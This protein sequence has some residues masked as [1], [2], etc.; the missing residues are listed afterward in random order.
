MRIAIGLAAALILS[1]CASNPGPETDTGVAAG[2][3]SDPMPGEPVL[4]HTFTQ[5]SGEFVRVRLEEGVTYEAELSEPVTLSI[6][7]VEAGTIE[8]FVKP[9]LSGTSVSGAALY[10]I[11]PGADGMYEVRVVGGVGTQTA[12]LRLI[13]MP[14]EED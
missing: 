13:P 6:T 14:P 11:R 10:E 9:V 8:P 4:I 1:A 3:P 2:M 7:P 12:T 5:G